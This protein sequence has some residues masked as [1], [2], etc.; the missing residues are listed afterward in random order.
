MEYTIFS[1]EGY[2]I[3]SDVD[4]NYFEHA[5]KLIELGFRS[6]EK[7]AEDNGLSQEEVKARLALLM[8]E[9]TKQEGI[10]NKNIK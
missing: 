2:E 9:C 10:I 4:A 6:L 7:F 5:K 8:Q 3:T 1:A